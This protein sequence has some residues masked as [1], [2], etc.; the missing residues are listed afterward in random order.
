MEQP[1]RWIS[2]LRRWMTILILFTI[3]LAP[4]YS[5]DADTPEP[6]EEAIPD[7]TN[8]PQINAV[9]T[10]SDEYGYSIAGVT[11]D[12][13]DLRTG[14]DSRIDVTYTLTLPSLETYSGQ[15]NLEFPN[16]FAFYENKYSQVRI[17][18]Y[19]LLLFGDGIKA[20]LNQPIPF[21]TEPNN[22][23]APFWDNL[24]MVDGTI[25][26]AIYYGLGYIDEEP[27]F[28]VEWK[29]LV[30]LGT[31][32]RV[33]TFEVILFENGNI[34]LQYQTLTDNPEGPGYTVGIENQHS[35]H[36]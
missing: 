12:W 25:H 10:T 11:Y 3:L 26:S 8:L 20:P 35:I 19:G 14:L 17:S 16:D 2:S 18:K 22:F 32:D 5:A 6:P 15:I 27:I 4:V 31:N 23:I 34:L 1:S 36:L 29:D 24:V 7:E 33:Q 13:I 9:S 28:V 21:D 30:F